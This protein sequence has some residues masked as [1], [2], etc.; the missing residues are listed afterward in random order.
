MST[1]LVSIVTSGLDTFSWFHGG[2]AFV[3]VMR[4]RSLLSSVGLLAAVS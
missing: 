2:F 1:C 3:Y 4:F